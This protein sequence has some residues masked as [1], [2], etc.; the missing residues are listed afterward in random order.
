MILSNIQN[1]AGRQSELSS[2]LL[3]LFCLLIVKGLENEQQK[4]V[5]MEL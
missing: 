3:W 5:Q 1:K 2:P 4:H